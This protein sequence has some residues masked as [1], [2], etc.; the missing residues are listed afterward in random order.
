MTWDELCL[1][2]LNPRTGKPISKDTLGRAF[3]SELAVGKARFKSLLV[4]SWLDIVRNG[5]HNA[6]WSA[7]Q[8]GLQHIAGFRDDA[9]GLQMNI[10]GDGADKGLRVEFIIPSASRQHPTDLDDLDA[11]PPSRSLPQPA[12]PSPTR[13]QPRPDDLVLDKVQP[14]AFERQRGGFRWK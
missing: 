7:V 10:G 1:L 9:A 13:I 3:A 6:R 12:R 4:T 5:E 2:V 14:S 11:I 8:W